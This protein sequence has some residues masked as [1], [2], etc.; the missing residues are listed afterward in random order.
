MT[1]S[2]TA[3]DRGKYLMTISRMTVDK[4]GV[5]LYDKVSAVIAELVA[6]GYDADAEEVTIE[7]P[8]GSMLA[9][10]S[11]GVVADSGFTITVSDTGHGMNPD[12]VNPFY[13]KVGGERRR[14]PARG[15]RTPIHGRRVMGRKGVGK[16]APFGIC[17]TLEVISSGGDLMDGKDEN[18]NGAKGYRTA[19]FIMR[20]SDI[21]SDDDS[22][23]Q[24]EIGAL[25]ETVQPKAGTKIIMR[26]FN[27]RQVPDM[28]IFARQLAQRFGVATADWRIKL[29]DTNLAAGTHGRERILGGFEIATMPN[30]KI[31]LSGPTTEA[32]D[33]SRSAEF[34]A[35]D[36]SGRDVAGAA[37]G[38]ISSNGSFYP[39]VGW[40][41][42]AKESYRDDLMAGRGACP[43][44]VPRFA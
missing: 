39:V 20:R 26:D 33:P 40:V 43:C 34:K 21:M 5:K 7:A 37:A 19:H 23:Y 1:D 11:K 24:P 10:L 12:V 41:A 22:D 8:M 17:E 6:N 9:S 35:V 29:V 38:F 42:Y 3:E 2:N 14:D 44:R 15:D 31:I 30:T 18:G 25:D 36:E 13:L 27:R 16:L 32:I 28:D 4:L